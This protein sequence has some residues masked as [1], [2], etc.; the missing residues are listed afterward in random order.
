M[1]F[2]KVIE[3]GRRDAD[4]FERASENHAIILRFEEKVAIDSVT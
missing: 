1:V 4:Q 2:D 3:S